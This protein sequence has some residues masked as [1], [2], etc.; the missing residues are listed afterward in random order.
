MRHAR[1]ARLLAFTVHRLPF[2]V[3]RLGSKAEL[4]HR[5]VSSSPTKKEESRCR[6]IESSTR[7]KKLTQSCFIRTQ[8]L[9][10]SQKQNCSDLPRKCG[11]PPS[12]SR[13][14]SRKAAIAV[15]D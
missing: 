11:A 2:T 6:T 10:T 9:L 12:R 15:S 5:R 13:Q 7:G 4:L 1:R 3:Y 8:K 14:I